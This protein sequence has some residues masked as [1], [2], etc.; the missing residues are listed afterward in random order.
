MAIDYWNEF[1]KTGKVDMYLKYKNAVL[2]EKGIEWTALKQEES[3]QD[4]PI[5]ENQ[6]VC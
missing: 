2:E 6:T 4:A 5:T 3:L 1:S